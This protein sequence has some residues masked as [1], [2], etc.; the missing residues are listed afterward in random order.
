MFRE[1]TEHDL[2]SLAELERDANLVGLAHVV[3]PERYPCPVD[4]VLARWRLVLDDPTAVVG[5]AQEGT[6]A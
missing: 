1:A 5:V 2:L 4:A 3:P 6:D